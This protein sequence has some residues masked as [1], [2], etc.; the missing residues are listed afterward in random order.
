[1]FVC[2][3]AIGLNLQYGFDL[4]D[5]LSLVEDKADLPFESTPTHISPPFWQYPFLMD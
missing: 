4:I 5:R 2:L 1:M 3:Y